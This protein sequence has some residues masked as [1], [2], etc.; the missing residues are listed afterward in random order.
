MKVAAAVAAILW[1]IS[2]SAG[3]VHLSAYYY[4]WYGS[5]GR[6][7]REGYFGEGTKDAPAGGEY[8]SRDQT[9]IR[10]QLRISRESGIRTW[11]ASWWGPGSWEDHTLLDHVLPVL[12]SQDSSDPLTLCL[13]YETAG[14]FE[15]DPV[16]GIEFTP[17][18]AET[19]AGHFRHIAD[20][21]FGSK[22]YRRI[23]ERPVVYFYLSRTFTG[24][25][26]RA[27]AKARAVAEAKGF[28]VFLV[29]DEV[30]W[31]A[32]D[33]DR[34]SRFDAIT[35]Y[36]MHGP[37]PY[38]GAT[39]WTGFVTD[40]GEVYRKYREAAASRKVAF[41]PG[42]LPGFDTRGRHYSI[43]RE[44]FPG[45]GPDSTL[46]A[47]IAMAKDHLDPDLPCIDLTSFNEWHEGSQV[48]PSVRG[49]N[50]GG[51]LRAQFLKPAPERS[52]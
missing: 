33:L 31:G 37:T 4:P 49:E 28:Q 13:L 17:A 11:I 5:D 26:T 19:L 2:G 35:S 52:R 30:Y 38:A 8:S 39:D 47:F 42:I 7:W 20:R 45:A 22:I 6:H 41:F 34:I 14:L 27:L 51:L 44:L 3:D 10:N 23:G 15:L 43:P 24:D 12:E 40:C 46:A 9:V 48:E 25:Y 1:S 18:A 29:G 36:N 21:Y 50:G 16:K 32:P